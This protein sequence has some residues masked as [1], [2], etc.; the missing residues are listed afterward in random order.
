MVLIKEQWVRVGNYKFS[1][2][3]NVMNLEGVL[4]TPR[5][6]S[7]S[8]KSVVNDYGRKHLVHT[9]VAE[10]FLPNPNGFRIV[11]HKDG[12][13]ENNH[14]DN[15]IW[16]RNSNGKVYVLTRLRD[17]KKANFGTMQL[18]ADFLK[19][20]KATVVIKLREGNGKFTKDGYEV[21]RHDLL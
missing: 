19:M 14:V 20:G 6:H 5:K 10:H 4:T 3:G 7:P 9:I 21:T 15:L 1:N 8:G 16:L 18:V 13:L 11:K 12:N 2:F 17:G